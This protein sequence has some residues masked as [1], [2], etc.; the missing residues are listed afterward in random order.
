MNY[1]VQTKSGERNNKDKNDDD[2]QS[3]ENVETDE[4]NDSDQETDADGRFSF[5]RTVPDEVPLRKRKI[6]EHKKINNDDIAADKEQ[7][8]VIANWIECKVKWRKLCTKKN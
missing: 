6:L 2:E 5:T 7:E 1:R 3:S 4:D 8:R